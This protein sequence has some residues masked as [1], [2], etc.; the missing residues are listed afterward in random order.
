MC[1]SSSGTVAAIDVEPR[2]EEPALVREPLLHRVA[3]RRAARAAAPRPPASPPPRPRAPSDRAPRRAPRPAPA[4]HDPARDRREVRQHDVAGA[5]EIVEE[6]RVLHAALARGGR[7]DGPRVRVGV[8]LRERDAA[9]ARRVGAAEQA[10]GEVVREPA[11]ADGVRLL[12][13][14]ARRRRGDEDEAA[15]PRLLAG[16][17]VEGGRRTRALRAGDGA[18]PARVE[19]ADADVR[20]RALELGPELV[21]RDAPAPEAERPVLRVAGVVDEEDRPIAVRPGGRGGGAEL[22][23]RAAERARALGEEEARVLRPDAADPR[24]DLVHP[25]GVALRVAEPHRPR[26][27]VGLAG[28]EREAP[29]RAGRRARHVAAA[30]A[31]PT[32]RARA[33]DHRV[34]RRAAARRPRRSRPATRPRCRRARAGPRAPRRRR[35]GRRGPRRASP[36]RRRSTRR[37]RG[38]GPGRRRRRRA[39]RPRRVDAARPPRTGARPPG[40]PRAAR[41]R[42][43]GLAGGECAARRRGPTPRARAP[44]HP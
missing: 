14:L 2:D 19:E 42:G 12:R 44:G 24:Q 16:R 29:L 32:A 30:A 40:A 28:D 38:A 22:V 3:A 33:A 26:A 18:G 6:H 37:R 17:D 11:R 4:K 25:A 9:V 15:R 23:E 35:G 1:A 5:A 20:G 8:R 41:R 10:R 27:A 7:A 36:P 31:S 39:R 34:P 43:D 21:E 13:V